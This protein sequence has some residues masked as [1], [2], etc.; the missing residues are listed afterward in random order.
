MLQKK[1]QDTNTKIQIVLN[2]K[3]FVVGVDVAKRT[4]DV[5]CLPSNERK[6]FANNQNGIQEMIAWLAG[7]KIQ[8]IVCEAT[9]GYEQPMLIALAEA[10]LPV[11]AVNPVRVRDYA[12]SCGVFAKTDRIDA[13]I[14]AQFADERSLEAREIA[15]EKLREMQAFLVW[16]RQLIQ[17]RTMHKNH[18]EHAVSPTIIQGTNDMIEQ[19]NQQIEEAERKMNQIIA[20]DEH[21]SRIE[22]I[23]RS[24]PGIGEE[25]TRT[26]IWE[27]PELGQCDGNSLCSYAGLVP[28]NRDSGKFR[29]RRTIFGGRT[30]I[31]NVLYMAALVAV[32]RV[33][34]DNVFKQMYNK[35]I[36]A[37]KP[38]K[39]ALIAVARKMLFI[40]NSIVKNNVLWKNILKNS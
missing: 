23:L 33:K 4:L 36:T 9:G 13:K 31:R 2:E 8:V 26:L 39:V 38:R 18:L 24:V 20:N 40:A 19:I 22:K 27:C 25:V 32:T 30:S 17:I 6:Q 7:K 12:K 37:N 5:H 15:D 3:P 21:W 16:R 34:E 29:G 1:L 14:I 10:G 11:N 35:F 28:F